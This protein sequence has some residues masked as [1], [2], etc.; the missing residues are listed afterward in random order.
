MKIL[1][2]DD[3]DAVR[4]LQRRC[5][6][7]VHEVEEANT[8]ESGLAKA[9]ELQPD[10]IISDLRLPDLSESG[11]ANELLRL[12]A[13]AP[14]AALIVSSG[15]GTPEILSKVAEAGAPFVP[16]DNKMT[17]RLIAAI[18]RAERPPTIADVLKIAK[19]VKKTQAIK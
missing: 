7:N 9:K 5:F 8:F 16:K 1:L 13:A 18:E 19:D 2:I 4:E 6:P 15:D 10:V 11:T 17:E 3:D 14:T 12:L